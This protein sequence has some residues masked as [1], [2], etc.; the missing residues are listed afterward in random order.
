MFLSKNSESAF[1]SVGLCVGGIGPILIFVQIHAEW[2]SK[3]P[4]TLSPGYL[5][6]FLIIYF[7]WFLYGLRFRRVAGQFDRD[8]PAGGA[9]GHRAV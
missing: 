6:G 3:T 7:F 1:E 4:S 2:V 5:A 9:A 8:D